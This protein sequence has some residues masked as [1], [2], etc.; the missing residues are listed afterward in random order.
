R[1]AVLGIVVIAKVGRLTAAFDLLAAR[2]DVPATLSA[3]LEIGVDLGLSAAVARAVG[4][5]VLATVTI[6]K[7]V[8][9][10]LLI[11]QTVDDESRDGVP[12]VAV[13]RGGDRH[14]G[15]EVLHACAEELHDH[16][17][18][19]AVSESR[20]PVLVHAPVLEDLLV[21]GFIAAPILL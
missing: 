10:A 15:V 9:A 16:L 21:S 3:D 6:V 19:G 4:D 11:V 12:F 17:S 20:H 14:H 2:I 5:D 7:T 13:N 1:V 18:T 8:S